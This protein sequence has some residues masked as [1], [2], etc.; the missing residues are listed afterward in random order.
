MKPNRK[1]VV[2]LVVTKKFEGTTADIGDEVTQQSSKLKNTVP[3]KWL[4]T[5]INAG[6]GS[7][8]CLIELPEE[9][10]NQLGWNIDDALDVVMVEDNS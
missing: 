10:L 5:L 1:R 2:G 3:I 6:D 7:G 8:D 9:L 4:A